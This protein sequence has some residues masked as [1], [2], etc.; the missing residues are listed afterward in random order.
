MKKAGF[1]NIPL[2]IDSDKVKNL[3]GID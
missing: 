3:L 2:F 1:N